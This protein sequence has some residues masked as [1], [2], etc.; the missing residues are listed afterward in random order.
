MTAP[1]YP[2]RPGTPHYIAME[3]PAQAPYR[4]TP[5]PDRACDKP[6]GGHTWELTRTGLR[7]LHCGGA[8]QAVRQRTETT[9]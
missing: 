6:G 4:L 5:N 7:C 9:P 1:R 8:Y 2:Q 3:P